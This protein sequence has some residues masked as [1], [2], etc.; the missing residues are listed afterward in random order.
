MM[1]KN[2][3]FALGVILLFAG[4]SIAPSINFT[5]V[6]ASIENDL[7]E[8]TTQ[9]CGIK[10]FG[11]TTVKL[12]REQYQ[13]LEQYLAGFRARLNQTTTR[14]EAVPIFKE[15]VVELDKYGL[16]PKEMSV[17]QARKLVTSLYQNP[18][19]MI[20]QK[21]LLQNHL[22]AQENYS[23]FLCLI[24][25]QTDHT[26]FES[27]GGVLFNKIEGSTHSFWLYAFSTYLYVFFTLLCWIN[28]L[29]V[30]NRI[31]LGYYFYDDY[32]S[33]PVQASGWV[34]TIGLVGVKN[35]QGNLQGALPIE[36]THWQVSPPVGHASI[37]YPA[38]V[39]FVGIKIGKSSG[40]LLYGKDFIYIGSAL[41]TEIST[42]N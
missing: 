35:F 33:Y 29:A 12:T 27:M 31:N 22:S 5:I 15:A 3:I 42:T 18:N 23:N 2:R 36:G 28:L 17:E 4:V 21:K 8:V 37:K 34:T 7:V 11:N 26:T 39:G 20:Y 40:D 10:G 1:E 30:V 41:W 16:L 14:E 13:D 25:G 6:K 24:A 38:A 32:G 9:A 19:L